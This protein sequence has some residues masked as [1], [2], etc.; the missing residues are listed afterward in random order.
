VILKHYPSFPTAEKE[1]AVA[2]LA[3]RPD[4]AKGL[5]DAMEAGTVPARDVSA[6]A[7]LQLRRLNKPEINDRLA[8]VWG[9][10]RP[11]PAAKKQLIAKLKGQLTPDA[12]KA[13]DL[14]RGRALFD[15]NCAS[16]HRLFGEGGTIGPDLTGSQRASVEYVLENVADPSAVVPNEYRV[17][18]AALNS[19][20]VVSGIVVAQNDR[21]VTFQTAN[22][23][24]IIDRKDIDE[25]TPTNQSMMPE[26]ILEKMTGEEVRDLVAY[27]AS[28]KQVPPPKSQ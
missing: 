14:S 19:G 9:Q 22:E 18:T 7:V 6:Y 2:T 15:R 5:L 13:G 27:L 21:T 24:L 4:Y 17:T 26:G 16:C 12:V 11:T 8:K 3:A 10:A 23:R 1:S 25:S 20:R 28:P